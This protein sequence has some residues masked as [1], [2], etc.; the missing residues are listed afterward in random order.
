MMSIERADVGHFGGRRAPSPAPTMDRDVEP[1][2]AI[3]GE[4]DT[5]NI[6]D[7][8]IHLEALRFF[9]QC[10]WRTSS[11]SIGSLLPA[12]IDSVAETASLRRVSITGAMDRLPPAKRALRAVRQRL[13]MRRLM[14]SLAAVRAIC[15]GGGALLSDANLHFPQSLAVL[16]KAVRVL[17]KPLLCLGCSIEGSWSAHGA[18]QI[19]EFLAACSIV[20]VRDSITAERIAEVLSRPVPVFGDF[21]LTE[22]DARNDAHCQHL[23][24][25]LALNVCEMA[26]Q[27]RAEQQ[28]YEDALVAL[29]RRMVQ[30]SA[31]GAQPVRI[32]TTGTADDTKP[33]RR[34]FSRLAGMGAEL[35]LPRTLDELTVTLRE[36]AI[37]VATRLHGA[38]LAISEQAPVVGFSAAP[39][40]RN[41]LLTMQ[42][43][44]Y[45]FTLD[46][47]ERLILWLEQADYASVLAAQRR[48]LRRAPAWQ[49]RMQIRR[50]LTSLAAARST[51]IPACT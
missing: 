18:K 25:G 36:S 27:W 31:G 33:A 17:D 38:I 32:F 11:Y 43:E 10:G 24:H 14:P 6:G 8:A 16:T 30:R 48:A 42:M 3:F 45:S 1:E 7:R 21:C 2:V 9:R 37:T 5:G 50:A 47:I 41:F 29:A 39:K 19:R 26:D 51:A 23:R 44:E 35:H 28:R 13:R 15:V 46:E 49:A 22:A 40:L 12:R 34:V 4:C 20:A